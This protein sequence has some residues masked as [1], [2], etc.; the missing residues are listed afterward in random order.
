MPHTLLLPG[1]WP[2]NAART[3]CG[4]PDRLQGQAGLHQ[5]GAERHDGTGTKPQN[6]RSGTMGAHNTGLT[7]VPTRRRT[8]V[9][10][11]TH[12]LGPE[13]P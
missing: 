3:R 11:W 4:L 12:S 13:T 7:I 5:L 6:E 8:N 2:L 10:E 9:G 1:L